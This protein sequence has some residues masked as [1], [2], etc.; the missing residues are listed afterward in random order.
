MDAINRQIEENPAA[1]R[2]L[3]EDKKEEDHQI[4]E[5]DESVEGEKKK[6]KPIDKQIA[7]IEYKQN[8]EGLNTEKGITLSRA[9]MNEKRT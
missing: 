8:G 4:V 6:R 5:P 9:E 7:F 3:K 2:N 1:F